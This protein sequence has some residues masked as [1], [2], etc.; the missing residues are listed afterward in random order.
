M[1]NPDCFAMPSHVPKTCVDICEAILSGTVQPSEMD[2]FGRKV[3]AVKQ[4]GV[5]ISYVEK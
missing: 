4:K 1:G 2:M 5:C 3:F